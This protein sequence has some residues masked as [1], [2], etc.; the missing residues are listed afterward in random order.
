MSDYK[1]FPVN[2]LPEPVRGLVSAGAAAI[3]CDPSYIALPMLSA[4][5]AAI[6]NTRR[7]ILKNT[8]TEPSVLWTVIIG[9][10]GTMKS[11]AIDLALKAL[12]RRQSEAMKE[13]AEQRHEYDQAMKVYEADLRKWQRPGRQ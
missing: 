11:P 9:E 1:Q 8:W 13:Y 5:A 2:R 6:G 3:G 10:S 12:R 4:L 7:I